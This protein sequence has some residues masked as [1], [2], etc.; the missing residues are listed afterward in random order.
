MRS[1]AALD[2][3]LRRAL[4]LAPDELAVID[5]DTRLTYRQLARRTRAA[6]PA[7]RALGLEP[8]DR[9]SVLALNSFRHLE[10]WFAVPTANLVVNDLNIRLTL[11]ELEFIINDCAARVLVCDRHHV[12]PAQA[13][14]ERCPSL[15]MLVWLDDGDAPVGAVRWDDLCASETRPPGETMLDHA[16]AGG[17][18]SDT[19]ASISYTGGTTGL[20]KGVMQSH[21][22][23][24]ANAKHVL[25]Q[26][27]L[28][29]D[30]RF[31]HSAPMFHAA[32]VANIYALT[33]VGGTHV[34]APR[35]EPELFGRLMEEHEGTVAVL[36]PTMVNMLLQH[37]AT[38]SRDLHA[39]RLLI[40]AASPMPVELL[41]RAMAALPC[42]FSQVYG[43][44]EASPHVS[45]STP[46]DHRRAASGLAQ[47][48]VRLASCGTPTIG[49]DV[50]VRAPDGRVCEPGEIGEIV[51]RGP[52]V[53]LGY[54][55]RP[56]ETARAFTPDGWYRSGDLAYADEH[57]YLYIVDRIKD[58]IITGGEN[59]Y[60]T[61]VENALFGIP[62][63]LEVAVFGIPHD[64][65]GEAVHAEV[66]VEP[67]SNTDDTLLIAECRER[68]AGFKVP[69]S[70]SVR[71]DPLPKSAAGKIL[72]RELRQPYWDGHDRAVN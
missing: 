37:P 7:L 25:L 50:E 65:W 62:G 72:K 44:T 41:K 61:E 22:N 42:D 70:V 21:G 59:V 36:V 56:E 9:V 15:T 17:I 18:R 63:V 35:F 1:E 46:E 69:R 51:L 43:M 67:G 4:Q 33:W 5:G 14:F 53:M 54:W 24:V 23:L 64:Q 40:Y 68:I 13:L 49:V 16:G 12:E 11:D 6:A 27:P 48:A 26:N 28:Y 3:P 20:P 8:G 31:L 52:N 47:D 10:L 38:A 34:I 30:D 71:L 2:S 45:G 57:G 60:T 66:V 55:Q 39:W 32:G 58:M 19:L 29:P